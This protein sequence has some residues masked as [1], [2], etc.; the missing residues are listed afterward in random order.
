MKNPLFALLASVTLLAFPFANGAHQPSSPAQDKPQPSPPPQQQPAQE[1][2]TFRAT[3][4]LVDV[5]ATV[6]ARPNKLASD[7]DKNAFTILDHN[8][9]QEI[10]YSTQQPTFPSP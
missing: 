7:L 8:P 10:R 3:V 4:N 6:L 2:P 1:G 5:L 9:P